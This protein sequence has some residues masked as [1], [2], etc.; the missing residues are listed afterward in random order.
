L[1]GKYNIIGMTGESL[2]PYTLRGE[3]RRWKR[4]A[5]K[6]PRRKKSKREEK[7]GTGQKFSPEN[8]GR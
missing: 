1:A 4:K 7:V 5:A 6:N 8:R 2:S 3:K